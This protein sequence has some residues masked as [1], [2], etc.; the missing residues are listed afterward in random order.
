[1]SPRAGFSLGNLAILMVLLAVGCARKEPVKEGGAAASPPEGQAAEAAKEVPPATMS[2][3]LARDK[4]T[5]DLDA[6]VKQRVIR[7]LVVSD[8]TN[9]LSM[10]SRCGASCTRC[11]ARSRLN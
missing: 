8:R 10:E 11:S 6:M 1:M 3:R 9:L 5:G 4:F 7:V 2:E